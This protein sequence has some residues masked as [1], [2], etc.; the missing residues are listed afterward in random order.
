V[1]TRFPELI[2]QLTA[3]AARRCTTNGLFDRRL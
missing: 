3:C 2:E 1:L